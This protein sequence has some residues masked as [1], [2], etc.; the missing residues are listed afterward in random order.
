MAATVHHFFEWK[1]NKQKNLTLCGTC[2]LEWDHIY[3]ETRSAAVTFRMGVV[4]GGLHTRS[5]EM[6]EMCCLHAQMSSVEKKNTK[7]KGRNQMQNTTGWKIR[8]TDLVRTGKSGQFYM[9]YV[10]RSH[11]LQSEGLPFTSQLE[12][13]NQRKK[14]KETG[15]RQQNTVL[16]EGPPS[17]GESVCRLVTFC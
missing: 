14:S 8:N 5:R 15:I 11:C 9:V 13:Q 2:K 16:W 7:W 1:T 4:G 10:H 6:G 12:K 17:K 3:T